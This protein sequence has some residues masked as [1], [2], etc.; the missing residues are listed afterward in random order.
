MRVACV[1]SNSLSPADLAVWRQIGQGLVARGY[2]VYVGN[3]PGPARY[4]P[5]AGTR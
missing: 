3:D 4:L 2:T 5:P 1:G